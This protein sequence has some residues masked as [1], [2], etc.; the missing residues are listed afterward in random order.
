[1]HIAIKHLLETERLVRGLGTEAR[2]QILLDLLNG[3]ELSGRD[4]KARGRLIGLLNQFDLTQRICRRNT[5]SMRDSTIDRK[6]N[7]ALRDLNRRVSVYRMNPV[8]TSSQQ[9][10]LIVRYRHTAPTLA[11]SLEAEAASF[12]ISLASV[13]LL[14]RLRACI[15]G[16][17]FF[18]RTFTQRFCSPTC[19]IRHFKS[20]EEWKAHRRKYMRD[21]Y[22]LKK[23]G[24]VK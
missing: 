17:W 3:T 13:R 6:R 21:Y 22:Q 5:R 14:E 4:R 20:S 19:R 10:G 7:E 8:C 12:I 18:G 9:V 23:S 16:K 15:C 2:L 24:K 1:M 11:Q